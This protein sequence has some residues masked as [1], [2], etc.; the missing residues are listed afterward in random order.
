MQLMW[1]KNMRVGSILLLISVFLAASCQSPQKKAFVCAEDENWE[2]RLSDELPLLGHRNWILVVDKAFP[3]PAKS[4]GFVIINSNEEPLKVLSKTIELIS[5]Q[6]H[7][8]PLFHN[9]L[10]LNYIKEDWVEGVC[11]Y[12][13]E[14]SK[15][16]DDKNIKQLPHDDIFEQFSDGGSRF[17]T[18][19]IKTNGLIPYSSVFIEL[20]CG[21]WNSSYEE[22]LRDSI[23]KRC[24]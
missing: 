1:I 21:Y 4:E 10:E 18:V 22:A 24:D 8:Q 5:D 16:I 2:K 14:L 23:K 17:R 3:M 15:L 11:A 19:I 9:D 6:P 20:D 7:I 12:R 13:D